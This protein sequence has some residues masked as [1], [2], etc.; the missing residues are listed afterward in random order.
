MT[1]LNTLVL[2]QLRYGELQG[3]AL[4]R[5]RAHLETCELCSGR[6]RAQEAERAAFVAT[7]VPEAISTL[8]RERRRPWWRDWMP[9]GAAALVAA[10]LFLVVR[11]VRT[12][13][14][15]EAVEDVVRYR[16]ELPEL[17]VWVKRAEGTR[18]LRPGEAVGAGDRVQLKYD[19]RGAS[20]VALAGRDGSGKIEVWTTNAP[21]G[22]GLVTAP[23]ALTL[24]D[25]PGDQE[26]FVVGSERP[27]TEDEVKAAVS[28]RVQGARVGRVVLPKGG[29]RR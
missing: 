25:T 2:H 7:P 14:A 20:S 11:D 4:E 18:R 8:G 28:G 16:G 22:L 27:L 24:D 29:G 1:H 6:L 23:F 26:L 9:I 19:P 15:P 13:L 21:T 17:E 3:P 12:E 5:A 10:T